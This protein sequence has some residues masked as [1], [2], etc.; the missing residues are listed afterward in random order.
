MG[1]NHLHLL[2]LF[3][4]ALAC[5]SSSP[6][7]AFIPKKSL[8]DP[9]LRTSRSLPSSTSINTDGSA[10]EVTITK[11]TESNDRYVLWALPF[12]GAVF[13]Y[14]TFQYT[15]S[16]FH[17]VVQWASQ[18][19]WLPET[20]EDLTL[21]ANVVTQVINGPVITSISLLFATLVSVTVSNLHSRQVVVQQ[22]FFLE[23][24]LFRQLKQLIES[25]AA[26]VVLTEEE[27]NL[28][29]DYLNEHVERMLSHEQTPAGPHAYIE[30]NILSFL[31]FCNLL[32]QR[33]NSNN[34]GSSSASF[35]SQLQTL[36][37]RMLDERSNRWLALKALHFPAVHYLTLAVLAISIGVSF[38]VATDEAEFIFLR[39]LPVRILW[40]LLF[41]SF[42]ALAVVCYDLSRPFGGAYRV[43]SGDDDNN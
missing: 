39:G 40:T 41:T 1:S 24:Q 5:L 21:Q 8:L 36:A 10:V 23:V 17:H 9:D 38:L 11:K 2:C 3:L 30:S 43:T 16:F 26:G 31:D 15:S 20:V 6:C 14:G 33:K 29:Q 7:L 19:T 22:S 4:L 42:T 32:E 28:A 34:N 18:N 13:S 27:R 25:Q 12:L 35:I 37:L